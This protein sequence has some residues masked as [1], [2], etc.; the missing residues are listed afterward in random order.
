MQKSSLGQL[1]RGHVFPNE[2]IVGEVPEKA[3]FARIHLD[4]LVREPPTPLLSRM[5]DIPR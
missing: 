3:V 1:L 5:F 2:T 4:R